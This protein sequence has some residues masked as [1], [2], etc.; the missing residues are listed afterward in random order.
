[1]VHIPRPIRSPLLA[2]NTLWRLAGG[3][4]TTARVAPAREQVVVFIVV[5]AAGAITLALPG[6]NGFGPWNLTL[7]AGTAFVMLGGARIA[8][9][10]LAAWLA[11]VAASGGAS[12]LGAGL[13]GALAG[14]GV[15]AFAGLALRATLQPDPRDWRVSDVVILTAVAIGAGVLVA[16][17]LSAVEAL[18]G[19]STTMRPRHLFSSA[20]GVAAGIEVVL[21]ALACARHRQGLRREFAAGSDV[22]LHAGFTLAVG[23]AAFL[24]T[25]PTG[26]RFWSLYFLPLLWVAFTFGMRGVA[27]AQLLVAFQG[28]VLALVIAMPPT[29]LANYHFFLFNFSATTLFLAAALGARRT[30]ER[31]TDRSDAMLAG[32]FRVARDGLVLFRARDGVIVDCNDGWL[33][34]VGRRRSEMLGQSLFTLPEWEDE[35]GNDLR[36][37]MENCDHVR[38]FST[39]LRTADG[40]TRSVIAIVECVEVDDERFGV[41]FVRDITERLILDRQRQQAQK[42]EVVGLMAG[43]A[44]H[45]FNNILTI[46]RAEAQ[47]LRA[48]F[49]PD[50]PRRQDVDTLLDATRRGA[51]L[52]QQLLAFS[53]QRGDAPAVVHDVSALIAGMQPLLARIMGERIRLDVHVEPGVFAVA[54]PGQVEQV[55]MNLTMNA[56]DAMPAGGRFE[57]TVRARTIAEPCFVPDA[58]ALVGAGHWAVIT[59]R[60]TGIGMDPTI[61]DRIFEPFFT[62]KPEGHGT[63]LGLP[64]VFAILQRVGGHVGVQSAA[65]VGTAFTLYWPS[66]MHCPVESGTREVSAAG[67]GIARLS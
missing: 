27:F 7:G 5:A 8:L 12:P 59:V 29:T 25:G 50:D 15:S 17:P 2:R 48:T 35:A 3:G 37:H 34:L 22:L 28:A 54:A 53:R 46:I 36:G 21:P 44:A 1:V 60:D 42:L 13:S 51:L 32:A 14:A 19:A 30:A 61:L 10:V 62:T 55:I 18:G 40:V 64:N 66:D 56:R 39:G 6:F 11:V 49:A 57:I 23:A 58:A 24:F 16:L 20:V 41:A 43:G 45:D 52:V 38:D 47:L 4:S 33:S 9:P 63:G 31:A 26:E 67:L 65:G